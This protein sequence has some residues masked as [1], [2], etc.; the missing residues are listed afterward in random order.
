MS[1]FDMQ[2]NVM[3][4]GVQAPS[5]EAQQQGHTQ[6]EV[7][8]TL[9]Q[10]FPTPQ[11]QMPIPL[12]TVRFPLSGEDAIN[13]GKQFIEEGEKLPKTSDIQIASDIKGVDQ[14]AKADQAFRG[15]PQGG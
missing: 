3:A 8:L 13:V 1:A 12:G 11:G 4:I 9:A 2:V 15:G 7:V 6:L 14:I 10:I 5:E